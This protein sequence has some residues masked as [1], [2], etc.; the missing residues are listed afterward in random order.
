M[1][2]ELSNKIIEAIKLDSSP[3]AVS[4][5]IEIPLDIPQMKGELRLCQ[6]LDK[7]RRKKDVFYALV[8]N[9]RCD[10]GSVSCGLKERNE[11]SR[12]GEFLY[13][14]LGLFGSKRA[15]RRFINSNP[16]IEFST[17]KVTTFAPLEKATFEPDVVVIICNAK[18]GMILT[19]ATT[20]ETG[21]RTLGMT[22]PPICSSIVAAPFLT[23]EVVYSMG[24]S[25]ARKY[26]K[27]TDG[28]VY[29]GIPGELFPDIVD[30]LCKLKFS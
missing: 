5:S 16:R 21:K 17:V 9:H 7:A 3:V 27:I 11:R 6:M 1:Y 20:F 8:E 29:V 30:N 13:S 18:Q 15:A 14:E 10:G 22:G 26:M 25:G 12:T 24:D 23:G 19:E 28:D 2:N 4:F